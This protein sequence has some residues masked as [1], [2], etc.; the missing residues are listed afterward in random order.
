MNETM[1]KRGLIHVYCGDGKGKTTA[2]IGLSI[3]ALGRNY[4]VIFL[5]FLKW[6][7]TGEISALKKFDNLT[8]IRGEDLIHKFTWNMTAEEKAKMVQTHNEMFRHA[9]SLC[10]SDKCLLIMDELIGAYDMDLIDRKMV[11]NYLQHKPENL[12][13][14]MTGRNPADELLEIAD[15][16]SEIKKVKHPMDQGIVAREGI[17]M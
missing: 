16:V 14:V 7:E 17:E 3:R 4:Q 10:T 5:Q 1:S 12:E 9:V 11:L 8:V 6:Q 2:A 15:Y 13:I